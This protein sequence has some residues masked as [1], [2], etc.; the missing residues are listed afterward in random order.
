MYRLIASILPAT[1]ALAACGDGQAGSAL[2][3][4]D[5][6]GI[7]ILESHQP[8]RTGEPGLHLSAG[9]TVEIGVAEGAEEYQLFRVYSAIRLDDGGILVANS[10]SGQLRFYDV[11]GRFVK[12][13]GR[14]GGGPGE[15]PEFSSMNTWRAGPGSVAVWADD[16]RVNVFDTS[17]A[18]LRPVRMETTAEAPRVWLRGVFGDGTWL[19]MAPGGGGTLSG[20][21][22][23]IIQNEFLHLRFTPE[24][25]YVGEL[26]RTP[27]RPRMVHE[28]GQRRHYPYIPLA[29]EPQVVPGSDRL[30]VARGPTH[31]VEV[32]NLDGSLTAVIRWGAPDPAR[33]ADI[34]SDY[35]REFLDA[36]TDDNRRRL[37]AHYF[38]E[39]LPLPD[40][41]PAVQSLMVDTDGNLWVER[42]RFFWDPQP[43]WDVFS[44]AGR[45]LS[46]VE[47]P[48]GLEIYE[49]GSD[50]VLGRSLDELGVERIQMFGLP[51]DLGDRRPLGRRP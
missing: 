45:W 34:W 23:E 42:F 16:N 4:R 36:F 35:E 5:S 33:T 20:L 40:R 13:A 27:G 30:Y 39:D 11:Q 9:P 18:L 2:T 48:E 12:S 29:P 44:E 15:F 1:L 46:T 8:E 10:G 3:E 26:L 47:T 24:G 7:R 41:V 25:T 28:Y 38:N 19:M 49:I 14:H 6:L 50:Y 22:G 17:G 21:P 32:W 43:V 37:Y 51:S 31:E